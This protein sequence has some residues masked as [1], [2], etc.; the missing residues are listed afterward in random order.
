MRGSLPQH[1][2][3]ALDKL[4]AQPSIT[5]KQLLKRYV[6]TVPHGHRKTRTRLSRRQPERYDISGSITDRMIKLIIAIDTSG[7]MPTETLERIM[8]EI[9]DIIG[10]RMC[11]V[12]V[13][14]CDAQIQRVYMA[15]S[16]KDI[17][18]D[19]RGRGGTSFI[20]VIEYINASRYFRDAILIC[21]TDGMGDSSIP[22]PLT[23]RTMWVLHDD[24]CELS[25]RNPY[26]EV[27]V[28]DGE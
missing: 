26:G 11:E 6:G 18:Y 13:I 27:L 22:K 25:V 9:F 19:I 5:W 12:T 24:Q 7:S 20:P 1:Q 8:V 23:L 14:E 15:H 2:Q 16:V 10:T 4:L 28:M 3:E 21:F 17:S